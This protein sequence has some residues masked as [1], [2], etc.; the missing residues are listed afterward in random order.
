MRFLRS[1]IIS[2]IKYKISAQIFY[3]SV[4]NY[5]KLKISYDFTMFEM[6]LNK[7]RTHR[8]AAE[9]AKN[10]WKTN[11]SY[12]SQWYITV[13]SCLFYFSCPAFLG[14]S[15]RRSAC[16]Y[17]ASARCPKK[18]ST[19]ISCLARETDFKSINL[20]LRTLL[21]ELNNEGL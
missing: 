7:R 5:L 15:G 19:Q 2:N 16:Q 11:F 21:L 14:I 12:I 10:L 18:P 17:L 8:G 20:H 13:F 1:K 9:F 6:I 3:E 4:W